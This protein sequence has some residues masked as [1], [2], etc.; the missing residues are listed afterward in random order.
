LSSE[1][2]PVSY[3]VPIPVPGSKQRISQCLMPARQAVA[4]AAK[5]G[6]LVVDTRTES[7][8]ERY[9]IPGSMNIPLAF[10][11]TKQFLRGQAFVLANDGQ[12]SAALEET[13]EALREAGFKQAA[14][15]RGGLSAWK[16]AKGTLEGDLLAQRELDRMR[17]EE[18]AEEGA[19]ADW[20]VAS[21][22]D[23]PA[24][25]L[26]RFFPKAAPLPNAKDDARFASDLDTAI[27]KR[28]RKGVELKVLVVDDDG[29]RI[30]KL[31]SRLLPQLA[32]QVFFLEGGLAGYR[33]FWSEQAAIWTALARG[34]KRPHCGA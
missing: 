12:A 5:G 22:A 7:E 20:L 28:T 25:E 17:P 10:V 16:K 27:A 19:Y 18:Y 9:R 11:K 13:C 26:T 4:L 33:R 31:Q 30:E 8:F 14:V 15:L 3:T 2:G 21:V 1:S 34:P 29:S 6:L 24:Q 23:V 32:G